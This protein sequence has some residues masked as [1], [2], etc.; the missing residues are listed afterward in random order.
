M[1]ERRGH[2]AGMTRKGVSHA[3]AGSGWPTQTCLR[4]RTGISSATTRALLSAAG[5]CREKVR[6]GRPPRQRRRARDPRKARPSRAATR[7][8]SSGKGGLLGRRRSA[9][10]PHPH[11]VRQSRI[12]RAALLGLVL[13]GSDRPCQFA[14]VRVYGSHTSGTSMLPRSAVSRGTSANVTRR[15]EPTSRCSSPARPRGEPGPGRG[16]LMQ[17]LGEQQSVP[18]TSWPPGCDR[19]TS[20][21]PPQRA[22]PPHLWR[23]DS[24]PLV[25]SR[26]H[27]APRRSL[28]F[29]RAAG[30]VH[31]RYRCSS[32]E[33]SGTRRPV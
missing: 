9:V 12:G 16:V 30:L 10:L 18:E 15:T 2:H 19:V 20:R 26:T 27:R 31:P 5:A 25:C 14:V 7:C 1:C 11:D 21:R 23:R 3:R 28:P 13:R 24:P 29:T 33:R 8:S 17:R 22:E 32:S 4:C 6:R